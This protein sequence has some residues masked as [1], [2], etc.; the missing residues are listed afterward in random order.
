MALRFV[1][2]AQNATAAR[3]LQGS[4][5]R[6]LASRKAIIVSV[7]ET[8]VG[9]A[10]RSESHHEYAKSRMVGLAALGPPYSFRT[11]RNRNYLAQGPCLASAA[12]GPLLAFFAG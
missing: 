3:S 6:L 2:S 4:V 12:A 9:W 8:L 11:F 1:G 7:A 10:E 5:A